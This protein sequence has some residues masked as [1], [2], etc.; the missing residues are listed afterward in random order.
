MANP[1]QSYCTSGP[2]QQCLAFR[3]LS[4]SPV[5]YCSYYLWMVTVQVVLGALTL[6]LFSKSGKWQ[7]GD[8]ERFPSSISIQIARRSSDVRPRPACLRAARTPA[9][10]PA[11]VYLLTAL[12]IHPKKRPWKHMCSRVA[13][14]LL[15]QVRCSSTL[16]GKTNETYS[17]RPFPV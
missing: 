12:E 9:S 13:H 5:M 6:G 3:Y 11:C 4:E 15:R 17:T 7:I 16:I 10:T 2:A 1:K 14:A 8:D